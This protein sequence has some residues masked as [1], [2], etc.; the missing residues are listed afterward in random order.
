M[1]DSF[2]KIFVWQ[3]GVAVVIGLAWALIWETRWASPL[4]RA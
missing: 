1:S 2:N 3:L 4:I